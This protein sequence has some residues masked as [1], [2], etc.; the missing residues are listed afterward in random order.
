MVKNPP[1]YVHWVVLLFDWGY[2]KELMITLSNILIV[3]LIFPLSVSLS[4]FHTHCF[5]FV[6][7]TTLAWLAL[8]LSQ[9]FLSFVSLSSFIPNNAWLSVHSQKSWF[10]FYSLDSWRSTLLTRPLALSVSSWTRHSLWSLVTNLS[11]FTS[12][13]WG[14]CGPRTPGIPGIPFE[15]GMP[16]KPRPSVDFWK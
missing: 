15:A 9:S 16:G 3:T 8:A 1:L 4:D 6:C 2:L 12:L 11:F 13:P 10:I 5:Q 14:P 7:V